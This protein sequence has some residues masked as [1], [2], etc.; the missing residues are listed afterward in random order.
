MHPNL[1]GSYGEWAATLT[2]DTPGI[3]SLRNPQWAD[4]GA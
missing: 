4:I 3:L 2:D 1:L